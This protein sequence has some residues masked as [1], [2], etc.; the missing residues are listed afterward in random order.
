MGKHERINNFG[1]VVRH[2]D[3]CAR[4]VD[5]YGYM[6]YRQ[7]YYTNKENAMKELRGQKL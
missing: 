1:G 6:G 5:N 4:H 2:V 7:R 3:I